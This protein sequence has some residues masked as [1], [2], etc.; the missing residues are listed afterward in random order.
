MKKDTIWKIL[1]A[2][3]FVPFIAP[4]AAAVWNIYMIHS[5]PGWSVFDFVFI[6]S[7]LYWPTYIIGL[8][9]IIFAAVKI[10]KGKSV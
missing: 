8:A 9:A 1:L 7:F 10:K 5:H 4:F 3:G 6:Y 2:I